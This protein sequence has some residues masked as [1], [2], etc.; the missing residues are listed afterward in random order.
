M[1][2]DCA[3]AN[4]R[5]LLPEFVHGSLSAAEHARVAAHVDACADCAAEA[6][7]IRAAARAFPA[8]RIDLQ[9]IVAALPSARDVAARGLPIARRT[10]VSRQ[11]WR[12]A[13][14]IGFIVL[15][16]V[17]LVTLRGTF[18]PAGHANAGHSAVPAASLALAPTAAPTEAPAPGMA[19]R[20]AGVAIDDTAGMSFGGGLSD[21]TDAQL[22]QLLGEIDTLEALPTAEPE[23]HLT[24]IIPPDGGHGAE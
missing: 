6:E 19:G 2:R 5:D 23:T 24:P 11:Q 17:S 1:M 4:L 12:L 20:A 15:G 22:D 21:L 8:P 10:A 3:D 14:A 7:L 18:Q 9:L 16:A 13:A